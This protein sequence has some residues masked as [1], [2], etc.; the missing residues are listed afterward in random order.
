MNR[1]FICLKH[2][3]P[4][5]FG[6]VSVTRSDTSAILSFR[7]EV[8]ALEARHVMS[9]GTWVYKHGSECYF[10]KTIPN[11]PNMKDNTWRAYG[12]DFVNYGIGNIDL[13]TCAIDTDDCIVHLETSSIKKDATTTMARRRLD[14]QASWWSLTEPP[15]HRDQ[16]HR[17]HSGDVRGHDRFGHKNTGDC[18]TYE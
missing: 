11:V 15:A 5:G 16:A 13:F 1:T 17:K 12:S 6:L 8:E 18:D 14:N 7:S 4:S 9:K 3:S 2:A 10:L